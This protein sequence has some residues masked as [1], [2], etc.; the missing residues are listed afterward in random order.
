MSG[1]SPGTVM[2]LFHELVP[3]GA[4][5]ESKCGHSDLAPLIEKGFVKKSG[6]KI[7]SNCRFL[8]RYIAHHLADVGSM[9]RLSGTPESFTRNAPLAQS[10]RGVYLT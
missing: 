1:A 6:S 10:L 8:E 3:G 9:V 7:Q 2:L 4:I 5:D